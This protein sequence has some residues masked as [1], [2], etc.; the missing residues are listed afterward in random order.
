MITN[1]IWPWYSIFNF[2]DYNNF[3]RPIWSVTFCKKTLIFFDI[4]TWFL[5]LFPTLNFG[6]FFISFNMKVNIRICLNI[7]IVLWYL[8]LYLSIIWFDL[9][10]YTSFWYW[11][12]RFV[13]IILQSSNRLFSS[14]RFS[15]I[16]CWVNFH[17]LSC[18]HDFID[19][20]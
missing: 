20:F 6:I 2:F 7:M 13:D 18:N 8:L 12:H 9:L 1:N 14:I 16:V 19:L 4:L 15:F 17:I 11:N 5:Y 10:T 3:F